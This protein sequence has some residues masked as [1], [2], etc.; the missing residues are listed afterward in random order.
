[1]KKDFARVVARAPIREKSM[2]FSS[3]HSLRFLFVGNF[4]YLFFERHSSQV[5]R[6]GRAAFR[7]AFPLL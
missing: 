3:P 2:I 5:G 6:V 4:L 1:M 7:E